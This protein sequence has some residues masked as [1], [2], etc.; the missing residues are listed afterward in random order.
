MPHAPQRT[1][2]ACGGAGSSPPS[3]AVLLGGGCEGSLSA[4]EACNFQ[5]A[6]ARGRGRDRRPGPEAA[7]R[8]GRCRA[9]M[10]T[11]IWTH[12]A[13]RLFGDFKNAGRLARAHRKQQIWAII[14]IRRN[15][16]PCRH[17]L[18][19]ALQSLLR[20]GQSHPYSHRL[21]RVE[22]HVP[23]EFSRSQPH[24]KRVLEYLSRYGIR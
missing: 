11:I 8:E 17:R 2:S 15:R 14:R 9:G 1:S 5:E 22:P 10:C 18:L 13:F 3:G 7:G 4:P 19:A 12:C 24:S 23:C 20:G 16:R 21:S 6:C